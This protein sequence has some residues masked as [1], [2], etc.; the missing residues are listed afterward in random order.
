MARVNIEEECYGRIAKLIDLIGCDA[1]EALGTIAFLWH[2]SQDILKVRGTENEIIE[3]CR[4]SRKSETE[5]KKWISVLVKSRFIS[6]E[7]NGIFLIH[8]NEIQIENR[9]KNI[10]RA[11]KGGQSLKKKWNKEKKNQVGLKQACSLPEARLKVDSSHD[12]SLSIQGNTIQGNAI[13][14]NARQRK[15]NRP[16]GAEAPT[17]RLVEIWNSNSGN[18]PRV[19]KISP[20]RKKLADAQWRENPHEE[21]WINLIC[22]LKDSDFCSGKS[23]SGWQ[24]DFDFFLNPNKQVKILEGAYDNR[25]GVPQTTYK[26]IG[27]RPATERKDDLDEMFRSKK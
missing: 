6:D 18:L 9:V 27:M 5:Q 17:C 1:R 10:A 19:L 2:D 13:Q 12:A 8:G 23:E 14:S 22:K 20:K 7:E 25:A 4:L 26:N 3:W 21:Y 15:A 24:A 11:R 16:A